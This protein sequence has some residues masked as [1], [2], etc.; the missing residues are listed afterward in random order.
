MVDETT[1]ITTA[2]QF[3]TF[4]RYV[5][6]GEIKVKF[7]D[8]RRLDL[9]GATGENLYNTFLKV[10]RDYDLNLK[11]HVALSCDGAAAMFGIHNSSHQE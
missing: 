3:I 11:Y 7:L 2:Q 10:T 4:V 9:L 6:N 5:Y 8:I 1:D